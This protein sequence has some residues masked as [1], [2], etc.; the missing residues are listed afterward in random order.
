VSV[1]NSS[2]D[3]WHF[4]ELAYTLLVTVLHQ[5]LTSLLETSVTQFLKG[6]TLLVDTS[7][8]KIRK[9]IEYV[10]QLNW[11]IESNTEEEETSEKIHEQV[12]STRVYAILLAVSLVILVLFVSLSKTT[13]FVTVTKPSIDTYQRLQAAY[14]NTLAC[15]CEHISVS[16][17]DFLS[18]IP[19]YHQVRRKNHM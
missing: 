7:M 17:E 2:H 5:Q 16:N 12:L 1:Q 14:P 11:F 8:D 4:L 3:H 19:T 15:P 6:H 10:S 9:A 13:V 18:I